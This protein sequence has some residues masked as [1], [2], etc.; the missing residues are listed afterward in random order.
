MFEKLSPNVLKTYV[1]K[2][3]PGLSDSHCEQLIDLCNGS[4]DLC[5]LE[6]D[7]I[8]QYC[9]YSFSNKV[10][11]NNDMTTEDKSFIAL[12]NSGVIYQPEETDVFKFT[13]AVCS[14]YK[15]EAFKLEKILRDNGTQSINMLGT[16]YNSIKS[17]MLIQCCNGQ[18]ICEVT[19]LDNRQ[20]YFNK[21]YCGKYSTIELVNAMK[22]I[23]RVIDGIKN[24]WIDDI[25]ATRYVLCNIM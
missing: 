10:K 12:L 15:D 3:C 25:Y 13:N 23:S 16:L 7:K 19:G 1:K 8:Q 17:I 22:L 11:M 6:V 21:K 2:A 14:R 24:G 20:V 4:Y 9:Q 18:N 5:M